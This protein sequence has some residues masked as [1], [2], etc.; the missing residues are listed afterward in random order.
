[1]AKK[2]GKT[3]A[4]V[5]YPDAQ[6]A[7]SSVKQIKA[8]RDERGGLNGSKNIYQTQEGLMSGSTYSL[9]LT[10]EQAEHLNRLVSIGE[11]A[12][13]ENDQHWPHEV[14]ERRAHDDVS[15]GAPGRA[16]IGAPARSTTRVAQAAR[17]ERRQ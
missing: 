3:V 8:E 5:N 17:K 4:D 1:M 11:L 15:Q 6:P 10:R 7:R 16:I 13:A 9:V 14:R 2:K 12:I